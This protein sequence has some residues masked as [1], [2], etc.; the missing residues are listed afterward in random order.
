M[1]ANGRELRDGG[2]AL[3]RLGEMFL[4]KKDAFHRYLDLLIR[5]GAAIESGE[6]ERLQALLDAEKLLSAE[7]RNLQKVIDP[8]EGFRREFPGANEGSIPALRAELE[9]MAA[10]MKVR[11]AANRAALRSRMDALKGEISG[12]R[13]LPPGGSMPSSAPSLIDITA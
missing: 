7:I 4:R 9:G 3:A 8:L 10:E 6:L 11:N 12:L 13:A 5:Q 2:P 1:P